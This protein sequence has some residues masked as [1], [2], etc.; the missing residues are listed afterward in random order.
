MASKFKQKQQAKR[1][2]LCRKLVSSF[3]PGLEASDPTNF[4]LAFSF[5]AQ[6]LA[7][8]ALDVNPRDAVDW[9]GSLARRCD[10]D[11]QSAKAARL[12]QLVGELL[13]MG[14][15]GDY[16]DPAARILH[17]LIGLAGRPLDT[18]AE[19]AAEAAERVR[20][21]RLAEEEAEAAAKAEAEAELL[22]LI[23]QP[24]EGRE[25][26]DEE[27]WGQDGGYGSS[28]TLSDWSAEDEE[29]EGVGGRGAA[30]EDEEDQEEDGD[31]AMHRA[32]LLPPLT[33]P[34]APQPA[35][36]PPQG[37]HRSLAPTAPAAASSAA[38]APDPPASCGAQRLRP[39]REAPPP[40]SLRWR[41]VAAAGLPPGLAGSCTP[42]ERVLLGL[43]A[44]LQGRSSELISWD[45]V[46]CSFLPAED[47]HLSANLTYG[48]V[49][50]AVRPLLSAATAVRRLH[51]WVHTCLHYHQSQHHHQ[52]HH[53]HHHNRSHNHKHGAATAAGGTPLQ[54]KRGPGGAAATVGVG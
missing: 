27:E 34:H 48:T 29:A 43:L 45:P 6:N 2:G 36:P 51:D 53:N 21:E 42:L 37:P 9:F 41:Q 3:L 35:Q 30:V 32:A 40:G 1:E 19:A 31:S 20:Q 46:T 47:L 11:S 39:P 26:E 14:L 44:A 54:P 18:S 12:R 49:H 24:L 4:D 13:H 16:T 22:A 38:V 25:D 5:V 23:R 15:K 50:T 28:S 52:R 33:R 7:E 8:P 17:L 10:E